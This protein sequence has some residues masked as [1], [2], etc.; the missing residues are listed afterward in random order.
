AQT[1]PDPCVIAAIRAC[2]RDGIDW[3]T[4]VAGVL[5]H[6][7]TEPVGRTLTRIGPDVVPQDILDAF[8]THAER[9]RERNTALLAGLARILDGLAQNGI[10]A[11]PFKGPV[12]AIQAYGDIGL[13][14]FRDLDFL[15][16]EADLPRAMTVL[17]D[18][19]YVRQQ[20]L[21]PVQLDLI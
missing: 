4:F 12:L 11:I 16:R 2:V 14:A 5:D 17:G 15:I 21:T 1:A 8:C 10:D 13:R 18:L 7:L 3:T 9:T 20:G 6:G 19:G